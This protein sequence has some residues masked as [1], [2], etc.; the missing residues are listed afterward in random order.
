MLEALRP[1]NLTE[2]NI[3]DT[4][5]IDSLNAPAALREEQHDE[6]VD[7]D[8]LL[9]NRKALQEYILWAGQHPAG[10]LRDKPPK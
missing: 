9:F 7:I 3:E 2:K 6:W 10:G 1:Q 5:I 8:E 4:V